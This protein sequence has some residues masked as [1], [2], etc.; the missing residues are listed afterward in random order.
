M[1]EES[2]KLKQMMLAVLKQNGEQMPTL[3][4]TSQHMYQLI[5]SSE[6][7]CCCSASWAKVRPATVNFGS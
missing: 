1:S 3:F 4:Y 7:T 2:L 6:L 5:P